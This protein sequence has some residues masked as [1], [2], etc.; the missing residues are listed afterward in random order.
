MAQS[1]YCIRSK[2]NKE[3]FLQSQ[4]LASEIETFYPRLRVKPVNPRAS[5]TRPY[6]PG[7]LFVNVDLD[8]IGPNTLQWMPGALGL[9]FYGNEPASVQEE[10]INA[11]RNRVEAVN[12]AGAQWLAGLK[13]GDPV[14]V[15]AGPFAG[16]EAIFDVRLPGSE[17]V[18]VFLSLLGDQMMKLE[19][20]AIHIKFGKRPPPPAMGVGSAR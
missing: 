11:I 19:L 5:K 15:E 3:V 10:L 13:A 8:K 4:L 9:V 6:F 16:Y 1:W 14:R 18:R 2:P 17:R 20:P 12:A 7:Y